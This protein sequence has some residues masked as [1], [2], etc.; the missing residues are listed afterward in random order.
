MFTNTTLAL[1]G[2][3][4]GKFLVQRQRENKLVSLKSVLILVS[5]FFT[6]EQEQLLKKRK[7]N[8]TNKQNTHKKMDI[9]ERCSCRVGYR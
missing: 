5:F 9:R 8:F 7:K 3:K 4:K 2:K 1:N 6:Q